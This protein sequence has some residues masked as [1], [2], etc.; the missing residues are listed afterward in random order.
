MVWLGSD[1]QVVIEILLLLRLLTKLD[2]E[3]KV[4]S[5][6]YILQMMMNV[7]ILRLSLGLGFEISYCLLI[8]N[9][10]VDIDILSKL[11]LQ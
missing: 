8:T 1:G 10:I 9:D 7:Y 2:K 11:T 3:T 5:V 6:S 4:E